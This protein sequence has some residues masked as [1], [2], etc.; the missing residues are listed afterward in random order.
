M[1]LTVF[2]L[3]LGG[4]ACHA[5]WNAMIKLR[6]D[7]LDATIL[8]SIGCGQFVLPGLLL[9]GM[10]DPASWIFIVASLIIHFLYYITLAEAYRTGDLGQVYPIARGAA[11]LL[12]ALAS[13]VVLSEPIG[14]LGWIGLLTLTSG[15]GLLSIRGGGE[16]P[17]LQRRAI[18]FALATAASI[19]AY[20]IVD[21]LGARASRAALAYAAVLFVLDGVMMLTF[22]LAWRGR[23]MFQG[24]DKFWPTLLIGGTLSSV[25]YAIAIWAMT[26]APLAL[27]VAVRETS[28][29]FAALLSVVLLKERIVPFRIIAAT[30]VVAG[31]AIIRLR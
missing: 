29:L 1:E 25:S 7:P 28:V 16:L 3:L 14:L 22:G 6:L 21:G 4:A 5:A 24:V 30:L 31:L 12:T 18:L 2:L 10:P 19:A 17:H 8:I 20:S 27:V 23:L 11:P 13:T 26:K 15:I 9:F